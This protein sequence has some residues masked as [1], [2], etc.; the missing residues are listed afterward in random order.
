MKFD[1]EKLFEDT[2]RTAQEYSQNIAGKW[3]AGFSKESK[4]N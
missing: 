2:K 1:L 4:K 3:F